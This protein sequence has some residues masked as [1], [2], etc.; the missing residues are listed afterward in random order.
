MTEWTGEV[1]DRCCQ[2]DPASDVSAL[3]PPDPSPAV[4][5]DPTV[6][7]AFEMPAGDPQPEWFA[8]AD[9]DAT[10]YTSMTIGGGLDPSLE[11]L[12]ATEGD[13]N[14]YTSMTIGG[15]DPAV[16]ALA[17]QTMAELTAHELPLQTLDPATGHLEFPTLDAIAQELAQER[18]ALGDTGL[19]S[20][21][22]I[23]PRIAKVL[24]DFDAHNAY[25]GE[26]PSA[27][28]PAE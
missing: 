2:D 15:A 26:R 11:D 19:P 23:D 18:A 16:L 24:Y 21:G 20:G 3:A 9:E 8:P 17:E 13:V 28:Q 5:S 6:D 7:P 14:G 1:D 25:A 4:W 10:G 27:E 22:G 12:T